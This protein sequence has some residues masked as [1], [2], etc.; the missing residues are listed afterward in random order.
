MSCHIPDTD[1][2]AT[3]AAS[4]GSE[5]G[6]GRLCSFEEWHRGQR[7]LAIWLVCACNR[8]DNT[9]HTASRQHNLQRTLPLIQA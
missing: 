5:K 4:L 7:Q 9:A 1:Y 2:A 8:L 6:A 3:A